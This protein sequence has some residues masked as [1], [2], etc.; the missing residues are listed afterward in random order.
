MLLYVIGPGVGSQS[1]RIGA[2]SQDPWS[3]L[4]DLAW[5]SGQKCT[6]DLGE[7]WA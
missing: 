1:P 7:T 3:C 6:T 4:P 2:R 5:D